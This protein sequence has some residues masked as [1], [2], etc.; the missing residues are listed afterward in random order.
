MLC[1]AKTDTLCAELL[2]LFLASCR[3]ICVCS[4]ASSVLYL[5][6]QAIILP[7][8]PPIDA[9]TVGI[10]PSYILPVE[11]SREMQSPSWYVFAVQDRTSCYPRPS[12]YRRSRIHSKCPFRVQQRQRESVMPPRTVRIPCAAFIPSISSGEV[13]RRT[14][15]TFSPL[16]AQSFAS[17]AVNTIL[18]QAAPGEAAS[19]L[20]IRAWQPLSA[21]ASNCGWRSVVKV[22]RVN[23]QQ[24]PSWCQ[25]CPR[26]QG[27]MQF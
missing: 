21:F 18:P 19:A 10:I 2:L 26:Q 14:R 17:S 22:T 20:A 23:H 9:S 13:S 5:S 12:R 3:C 1:T 7:K 8:S 4:D 16:A 25:S 6:A 24:L 27:H 15:T 11:P